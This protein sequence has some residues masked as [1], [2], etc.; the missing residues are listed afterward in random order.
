MKSAV[1]P[2]RI[3]KPKSY[4]LRSATA[5]IL[6]LASAAASRSQ[7]LTFN[8]SAG[9]AGH[10]SVDGTG[11]AALFYQPAATAADGAGNIYVA[12]SGNHTIRKITSAGVVSTLAGSTGTSGSANGTGSN[13][14][15]F[16]PQGMAVDA[17]GNIYVA[18]TGNST[19]RKITSAGV[20]STLAGSPGNV[21]SSDGA[22]TNAS[23]SQP[24]GIALDTTTNLY[25]ADYG[26]NTIRKITPAGVVTTLAGYA[27]TNGSTDGLGTNALFYQPQGVVVDAAF[28]VYVAD[29]A[30]GTIRKITPAGLVSTLAGSAGNYGS[31][32]GTGTNALFYQ[33]TGVALDSANNLFVT[34]YFNQTI[35]KVTPLGVVTTLAGSPGFTA[36]RMA[37]RRALAFGVRKA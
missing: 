13:A 8:S 11:A 2:R 31:T 19:I 32:N 6:L 25:V 22:G 27:G 24:Q 16:Q 5:C 30:N 23:F 37:P 1:Q 18:D 4:S 36:A 17:A 33:P 35:R 21:G 34:E 20:V 12:D 28:N 7:T 3:L 29:T 10:G 26:N 9:Y 14:L 15:F